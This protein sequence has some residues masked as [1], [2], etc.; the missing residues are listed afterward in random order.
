MMT[1][2]V[3]CCNQIFEMKYSD[4]QLSRF[5]L[6]LDFIRNSVY[7]SWLS[8]SA[9]YCT[10]RNTYRMIRQIQHAVDEHELGKVIGVIGL[11][12]SLG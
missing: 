7:S 11:R 10:S 6:Y 9:T 12:S 4:L 1:W 2:R 5:E 8:S 3:E